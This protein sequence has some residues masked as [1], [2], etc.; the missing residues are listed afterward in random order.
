MVHQSLK[1]MSCG[2]MYDQVAGGFHR[3]STDERWLVPHFEKMLYDNAL[4][5]T[6]YL[7]AWQV[8]KDENHKRIVNEILRY[9]ERDMT[10]PDG[11]FYSATDADSLTPEGR[12]EEGYFFTWTPDELEQVLGKHR[13][14]IVKAYYNIKP[15]PNFEGRYI[16]HTEKA[17][18]DIATLLNLSESEL[19][20]TIE[21]SKEILYRTRK[22]RPEPLRDEKILTAWNGLMISAFARAGSVFDNPG[23]I[24]CAATAARFIL[25]HLYTEKRL[26]RSYKDY[27]ARHNAYLEDY[28]FL[29]AAL[30]DLYEATHDIYWFKTAIELD[31]IL[32]E[33][34]EDKQQGGFFMT[35]N[36]HEKLIAREKPFSDSAVPSGNSVEVLNLLRLHTFTTKHQYKKRAESALKAF[37][38][39]LSSSPSAMAEM[40]LAVDFYL[41]DPFEIFIVSTTT[42]N[43]EKKAILE[44]LNNHFIPNHVLVVFNEQQVNDISGSIPGV[45]KKQALNGKATAFICIQGSCQQPANNPAELIE[46]LK[47]KKRNPSF[48]Q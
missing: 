24:D 25:T 1:K 44:A 17:T 19:I 30:L 16:L 39:I 2:G 14:D 46:Q 35:G 32:E 36:D 18:T 45:T 42:G 15:P 22:N 38:T 28:A 9:V 20:D 11:G 27:K 41:D 21:M 7:E 31:S 5:A 34:F 43:N 10:S 48:S 40:L 13:A 37:S 6:V 26:Y 47:K 33:K 3:Y 23:Y 12:M 4:Q 8:T 29:I